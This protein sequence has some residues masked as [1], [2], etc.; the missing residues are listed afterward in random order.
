MTDSKHVTT[1]FSTYC[2]TFIFYLYID[3]AGLAYV[4]TVCDGYRFSKTSKTGVAEDHG[5]FDGV[6]TVA[7]EMGHILGMN[8]DGD[9]P[10]SSGAPGARGCS[11]NNN[12]LMGQTAF[13]PNQFKWSPCSVDQLRWTAS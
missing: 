12:Y 9:G 10:S 5:A 1:C 4:G 13:V 7:H 8:H 3:T 11:W 6:K 2:F